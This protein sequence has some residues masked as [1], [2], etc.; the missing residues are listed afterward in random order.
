MVASENPISVRGDGYAEATSGDCTT[1]TALLSRVAGI[2]HAVMLTPN[3]FGGY[4]QVFELGC[5]R[6]CHVS[7]R[8]PMNVDGR[9][10][11]E[12]GWPQGVFVHVIIQLSG[13][14]TV[15]RIGRSSIALQPEDWCVISHVGR[16]L[17]EAST[18]VEF[19]LLVIPAEEL[20]SIIDAVTRISERRIRAQSGAA[21][22]FL[23]F[24]V[25]VFAQAS[26]LSAPSRISFSDAVIQVL[27][28]AISDTANS[29]QPPIAHEHLYRRICEIIECHLGDANL[30]VEYIARRVHCSK[31]YLHS[32][33]SK[34]NDRHTINEYIKF[35]RLAR[36]RSELLM[37][38]SSGRSIAEIAHRW[39]FHDPSYFA[40][41]FRREYGI[42]PRDFAAN[43]MRMD[44]ELSS[45]AVPFQIP[46]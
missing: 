7:C 6:A 35:R 32:L 1:F 9:A 15:N 39:G 42:A 8:S 19:M 27:K 44:E 13:T 18:P 28:A 2:P 17:T 23:Q 33:F 38:P 46:V 16:F 11:L 24:M 34:C 37:Q 45:G 25:S 40:R 20:R 12:S 14:M 26:V 29:R 3:D 5:L 36:C 10:M 31:R 21:R 4:A 43:A 41:L 22:L 30:S